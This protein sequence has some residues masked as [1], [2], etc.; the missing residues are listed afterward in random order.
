MMKKLLS[1]VLAIAVFAVG[2]TSFV[3]AATLE[4][5]GEG[6]MLIDGAVASPAAATPALAITVTQAEKKADISA[7]CKNSIDANGFTFDTMDVYKVDF[8]LSNLGELV[9]GYTTGGDP[10]RSGLAQITITLP[11]TTF[12]KS[13]TKAAQVAGGSAACGTNSTTGNFA[14]TWNAASVENPYPTFDDSAEPLVSSY[15]ANASLTL[16]I[17]VGLTKGTEL[18]VSNISTLVNYIDESL[19]VT[20]NT[21]AAL[22]SV[23]F[24]PASAVTKITTTEAKS[25][26]ANGAT[27]LLD[28][29]GNAAPIEKNYGI[30][31]FSPTLNTATKNYFINAKDSDGKE[32]GKKALNFNAQRIEGK[33]TFYVIIKSADH[34]ISDIWIEEENA[35]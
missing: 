33:A 13:S 31:K 25:N 19:E 18:N 16:T 22:Q 2:F 23:K 6:M 12:A 4:D 24:P 34:V 14:V 3:S 32:M 10:I 28:R 35:E 30:T 5:A 21:N 9:N 20:A 1:L 29:D 27:G 8:A 17:V 11:S 26:V 15:I 7:Y